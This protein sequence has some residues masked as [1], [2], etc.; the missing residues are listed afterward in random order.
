MIE[1][2]KAGPGEVCRLEIPYQPFIPER[3]TDYYLNISV[4]LKNVNYA[5]K[6][7]EI[8]RGSFC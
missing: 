2:L 3:N 7:H 5:P 6:G 1:E 4:C 8:S